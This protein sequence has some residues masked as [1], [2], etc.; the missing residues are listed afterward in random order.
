MIKIPVPKYLDFVY[1]FY[2]PSDNTTLREHLSNIATHARKFEVSTALDET[3]LSEIQYQNV[4]L[5]CFIND[6]L[7]DWREKIWVKSVL[8]N[9]SVKD[10]TLVNNEE[11]SFYG[12]IA[13]GPDQVVIICW[14]FGT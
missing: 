2:A 12:I 1:A 11:M 8:A 7:N 4:S 6:Y 3:L 9:K 5:S 14:D 13:K 10:F